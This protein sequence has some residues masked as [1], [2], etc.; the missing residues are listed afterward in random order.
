MKS[1]IEGIKQKLASLSKKNGIALFRHL[2]DDG[3]QSVEIDF[4]PLAKEFFKQGRALFIQFFHIVKEPHFIGGIEQFFLAIE[5]VTHFLGHLPCN[6]F[7]MGA[8]HF[9]YRDKIH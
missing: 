8:R 2:K 4:W 5:G 3:L 7:T 6:L 1:A 9:G